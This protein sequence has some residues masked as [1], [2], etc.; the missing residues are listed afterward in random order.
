MEFQDYIL[1]FDSRLNTYPQEKKGDGQTWKSIAYQIFNEKEI[2]LNKKIEQLKTELEQQ[3]EICQTLEN[4][5]KSQ[6]RKPRK[7]KYNKRIEK[8]VVELIITYRKTV[9]E[10]KQIIL[11]DYN[12]KLSDRSI[13]KIKED[14]NIKGYT[15]YNN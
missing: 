6:K 4:S 10:I 9:K 5:N 13:N 3:K 12:V 11:E 2:E 7:P 1:L 14:N 15:Q 8:K